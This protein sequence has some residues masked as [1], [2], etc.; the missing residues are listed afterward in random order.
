[1]CLFSIRFA[2]F[3]AKN[4]CK[5]NISSRKYADLFC[6]DFN[7]IIPNATIPHFQTVGRVTQP[8][9]FHQM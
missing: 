9:I 5:Q 8:L 2:L 7:K 4:V 6:S 1:M 3:V